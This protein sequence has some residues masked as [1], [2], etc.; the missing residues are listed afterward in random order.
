M[1]PYVVTHQDYLRVERGAQ[2]LALIVVGKAVDQGV[3]YV[4]QTLD[5]LWRAISTA[6]TPCLQ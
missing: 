5:R 2:F 6:S 4:V 3:L 1:T